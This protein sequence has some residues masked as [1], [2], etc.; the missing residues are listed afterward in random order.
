MIQIQQLKLQIPHTEEQLLRKAAKLL[1]IREQEIHDLQIVRRSLDARKK[2][3][4]FYV[5]T[6]C[7]KTPKENMLKKKLRDKNI[8]FLPKEIPYDIKAAGTENLRHRPVVIG[9]G[10]AGLFC[11]YQLARL[12]YRPILLER[13]ADVETRQ[14]DVERFWETGELNTNS[15]VQFGEGG[16]APARR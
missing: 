1:K 13:G 4:L 6:V 14:K 10:P 3:V 5:Y 16:S 9:T 15:N 8:S 11:G 12:G 2:P 7:L